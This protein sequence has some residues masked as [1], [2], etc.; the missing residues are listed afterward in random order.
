MSKPMMRNFRSLHEFGANPGELSASYFSASETT[1]STSTV[2]LLHGCVQ[3]GQTLAKQSGF[4]SLAKQHNF[5]LLIPQQSMSNNIKGCFN[6][7]SKQDTSKDAGELLSLK[8][9][10]TAF[11]KQQGSKNTFVVGLSAGGAMTSALLLNYPDLFNSGAIVAGIPYPCADSLTKA[12]SCMRSGPSTTPKQLADSVK[13]FVKNTKLPKLSIWTGTEDQ[14]VNP[15]NAQYMAQQW[16]QLSDKKL[17][18]TT[19]KKTGYRLTSWLDDKGE[20]SLELV[21]I[22]NLG[23][24]MMVNPEKNNNEEAGDFLL[25]SP[26][27]ASENIIKFWMKNKD[28]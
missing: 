7:F 6:W 14:V 10:V 11:T 17:V 26:I 5:N 9:M 2:V 1:K 8:N 21:E 18:S 16:L 28:I 22:D 12:I 20:S 4:L 3:N 23:H 13:P 24:G 27:S 15:K 19:E 25:K